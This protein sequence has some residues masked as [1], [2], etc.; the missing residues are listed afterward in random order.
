MK[1]ERIYG[2]DNIKCFLILLVVLGHLLEISAD[3]AGRVL[4]L[5][6]IYSFH[7]P[8]FLFVSGYFSENAPKKTVCRLG[9][10][11]CLFQ[12]LYFLFARYVLKA[13]MSFTLI[14]TPYWILWYLFVMIAYSL[15]VPLFAV[16][17]L[18]MAGILLL[19][20]IAISL[21]S[22][23]DPHLGY[24]LSA[25]RF[26]T[27]FPYFLLGFYCKSFRS[28]LPALR[29]RMLAG[30]LSCLAAAAAIWYLYRHPG[31][32]VQM[33]YGVHPYE[34]LGYGANIR[35]VIMLIALSW[36]AFLLLAVFPLLN[37][38]I[39]VLS[40]YGKNTLPIFLLHG[41]LV[42][43]M[44]KM[45]LPIPSL[46]AALLL[47]VLIVLLLGSPGTARLFRFGFTGC[48][49]ERLISQNHSENNGE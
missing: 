16:K 8:A 41:F 22:G 10:T 38:R 11:Y 2:F 17:R 35:A 43:L 12:L 19:C 30:T 49:R 20:S 9:C 27:F 48:R 1:K 40:A 26:F 24:P 25:A 31:I 36:I 3:F 15:L 23:Y 28:A 45:E 13:D 7:M 44:G 39:P 33:M 14:S 6:L 34:K 32:T 46:W 5:R 18:W 4:L 29:K 47:A 21:L 37:R 42:R